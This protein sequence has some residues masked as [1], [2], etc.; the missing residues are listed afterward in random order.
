[1]MKMTE[2]SYTSRNYEELLEFHEKIRV[3]QGD[4]LEN[5]DGEKN[6]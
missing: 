6:T 3:E 2:Q 1:M 4:Y 5:E